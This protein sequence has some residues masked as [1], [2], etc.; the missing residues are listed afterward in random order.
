MSIVEFLSPEHV[1]ADLATTDKASLL[2]YL[3]GKAAL[4]AD[5]PI[6]LVARDI[7][8]RETLGSTGMGGGTAIPHARI[9]GLKRPL[10]ILARL[11]AAIDFDA[12]DARPVDIVFLLLLTTAP[13]G[14]Q[15]HA[16][17]SLARKLR[18]SRVV[19]SIRQA[20]DP[21]A[22]YRALVEEEA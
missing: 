1:M 18:D 5:L 11:K 12:V 6:N 19:A 17:A 22:M 2:R 9:P 8:K 15:L 4:A 13:D 3:S 10:G 7:L 21:A 20:K 16:L 14:E